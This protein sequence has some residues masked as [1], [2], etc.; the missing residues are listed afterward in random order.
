MPSESNLH[1]SDILITC[2][3]F[4]PPKT[5]GDMPTQ[6]G[7][8][9]ECALLGFIQ[10][11]GR[12]YEGLRQRHPESDFVKVYTF[13]SARKSMSTIIRSPDQEAEDDERSGGAKGPTT[14]LLLLTKGAAEMIISK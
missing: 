13:S 14:K 12:D 2:L 1:V 3:P 7:N 4:Q 6:V 8:K 10:R 5:A 9:T 11:F